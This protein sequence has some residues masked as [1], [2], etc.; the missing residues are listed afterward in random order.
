MLWNES[1]G[2]FHH[3]DKFTL[4]NHHH[5]L[6]SRT[7]IYE[8]CPRYRRLQ[9]RSW[10]TRPMRERQGREQC[11]QGNVMS[12][13]VVEAARAFLLCLLS[14]SEFLLSASNWAAAWWIVWRQATRSAA[15]SDHFC[16]ACGRCCRW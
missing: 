4:A 1:S 7:K 9:A 8:V 6:A 11:L 12:G 14:L 15:R 13:V 3:C 10:L 2:L 5:G 16:T